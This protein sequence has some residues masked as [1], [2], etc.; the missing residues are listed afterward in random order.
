MDHD[1]L[2]RQ[3][4]EA[5][6]YAELIW[7]R[8]RDHG[9]AA[10]LK[11]ATHTYRKILADP[12]VAAEFPAAVQSAQANLALA[13]LDVHALTGEPR[14]LD[15]A[16]DLTDAALALEPDAAAAPGGTPAATGHEG[17]MAV[18]NTRHV[19]LIRR[20][21]ATRSKADFAAADAAVAAMK[22]LAPDSPLVRINGG[23][24]AMLRFD[25]TGA[26]DALDDAIADYE[27]AAELATPAERLQAL[28]ALAGALVERH[29]LY[30]SLDDL[31]RAYS[32]EQEVLAALPAD[33]PLH[34]QH[35]MVLGNILLARHEADGNLEALDA[36]IDTYDR[37]TALDK[38][39]SRNQ[40]QNVGYA[41]FLRY[42]HRR[43]V[44]DLELGI[45]ACSQAITGDDEK[46]PPQATPGRLTNLALGLGERWRLKGDAA[47]LALARQCFRGA[48]ADGL[49]VHPKV[50]LNAA[51]DWG[52]LE[53]EAGEWAAAH[54]AYQ[55]GISAL[56]SLF[57]AGVGGDAQE[58]WLYEGRGLG[59]RAAY[60]AA[61]AGE[62]V[63]AALAIERTRAV[64]WT[65]ALRLDTADLDR[66]AAVDAALARRYREAAARRR[67]ARPQDA[68]AA[69]REL[70]AVIQA[71]RQR[72]GL[73]RWLVQST[74]A[75]LE[76]AVG[77]QPIVYLA[78]ADGAG[79]ALIAT[80]ADEGF[81]VDVLWLP[82]L[83]D[84]AVRERL[85]G[86]DGAGE[87]GGYLALYEAW[88]HA[89]DVAYE[90]ATEAWSAALDGLM[91]WYWDAAIGPLLAALPAGTERV[92]L[93]TPGALGFLPLHAA[94]VEDPARPSGRR[95]ALDVVAFSSAP[96]AVVA[97]MAASAA[98]R[99]ESAAP[100]L[101]AV[102]NPLVSAQHDLPCA[103]F[104]VHSAASRFT[105]TTLLRGAQA[106]RERVLAALPQAWL[107]HFCCHGDA[108]TDNPLASA[109]H[110]AA[111][112]PLTLA[113]LLDT[114]LERCR[115]VM[116]SA[117]ETAVIGTQLID[118]TISLQ[119]ALLQAGAAAAIA[120]A[121][122]VYDTSAALLVARFYAEWR[123]PDAHPPHRALQL[124]QQW[125]RDSTNDEKLEWL[126]VWAAE[127]KSLTA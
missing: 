100:S 5:L 37:L 74:L 32:A 120:T 126:G 2:A 123:G 80:R 116:L 71:V 7:S 35:S 122:A 33:S 24:Q 88:M 16:I 34:A 73:E 119:S 103:A 6:V 72:P 53:S 41:R 102:E 70:A 58:V 14:W 19:A 96:N 51:V 4:R 69:A 57:E 65:R 92:Q 75:D 112:R 60:A 127:G 46:S 94:W 91:R 84:K 125:L 20:H 89:N 85:R 9:A 77:E 78:A 18:L 104:E 52:A 25:A 62:P 28:G 54:E 63:A 67:S 3:V 82:E 93:V 30:R 110:L 117:C 124:A 111:N 21:M 12:T 11:A 39:E 109:L 48:V 44:R 90:A 49:S 107:V 27:R 56:Q 26:I 40:L 95:Y 15:E 113:S 1:E 38:A 106:T 13:L 114:R 115:L 29:G 59:P 97:A 68:V 10:D 61:K 121:W 42:R 8:Y 47:D 36:A 55:A 118:E 76:A 17:R 86:P 108:Y 99:C 105:N 101:L 23:N 45:L 98:L 50:A 83:T 22:Q 64:A 31:A 66:V 79:V 43:D 87:L 81:H